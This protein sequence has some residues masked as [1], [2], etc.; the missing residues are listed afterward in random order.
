MPCVGLLLAMLAAIPAAAQTWTTQLGVEGAA[1][2]L[3]PAGTGQSDYIDQWEIPNTGSVLSGLFFIVPLRSRFALEYR[4]TA[5]HSKITESSGLLPKSS[6]SD[7][8]LIARADIAITPNLYVA[9]GGMLRRHVVDGDG[10]NQLGLV[11][12]I[13][14]QQSIGSNLVGRIEALWLVQQ[15]AD[16]IL[17]S[18]VYG[19]VLSVSR[20]LSR[21]PARAAGT[22]GSFA[23]WR[24]QLGSAGGYVRVHAF[25]GSGFFIDAKE[26]FLEIPGTGTT[27]PPPMFIDLPIR[28]RFAIEV[29][30][31]A[32]RAQQGGTTL[33]DLHFAPRMNVA[34]YRG[35]YAG[36]GG[37][38]WYSKTTGF[39]GIALSGANAA[40]GYRLPILSMLEGR[41]D[42]SY[43]TF[44]Q[45][46]DYPFA[47]NALAALLGVAIGLR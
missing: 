19:V 25:G 12:A 2:R 23:P 40:L 17:P 30:F 36:A 41:L 20:R 39:T 13:G 11:S 43:T 26:T 32:E 47:T 6:M 28:G 9:A 10:A 42:L 16:S 29:G 44:K 27:V 4:L 33:F 35:L 8:R 31:G 5:Q 15:K 45:R 38:L 37:N 21:A 34:V 7:T 14:L 46:R 24:L 18:N 3:K 22:G 1:L